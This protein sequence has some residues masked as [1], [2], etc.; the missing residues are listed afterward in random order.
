MATSYLTLFIVLISYSI[1]FLKPFIF[2]VPKMYPH[3][4]REIQIRILKKKK[5]KKKTLPRI[6][7]QSKKLPTQ[8]SKKSFSSS[9]QYDCNMKFRIQALLENR[10]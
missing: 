10:H 6:V 7:K 5:K 3:Y 9:L 8:Q 4:L 2:Q 1:S